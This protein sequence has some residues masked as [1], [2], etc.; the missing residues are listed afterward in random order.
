MSELSVAR[1]VYHNVSLELH[2]VL[3]SQ[4]EGEVDMFRIVGVDVD[5]EAAVGL[6]DVCAIRSYEL[7]KTYL[8]F[9]HLGWW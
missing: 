1:N 5:D 8:T 4:L 6:H 9:L 3:N 7:A 2:S